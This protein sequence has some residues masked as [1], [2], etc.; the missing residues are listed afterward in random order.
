M[1][2]SRLF[3]WG[4]SSSV[5]TGVVLCSSAPSVNLSVC[6]I[7]LQ[8]C[9]QLSTWEVDRLMSSPD[10]EA[11]KKTLEVNMIE[12]SYDWRS[13]TC[14]NSIGKWVTKI[15]D[16]LVKWTKMPVAHPASCES[17]GQILEHQSHT[18][19]SPWGSPSSV[20]KQ[21]EQT[22]KRGGN[23]RAQSARNSQI[24]E[25][26]ADLR[27]HGNQSLPGVKVPFIYFLLKSLR[28][29]GENRGTSVVK[30]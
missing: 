29:K 4:T 28:G 21:M 18:E 9:L 26:G 5:P 19:G 10:A 7:L 6:H 25:K 13:V 15:W 11:E 27:F 14:Q 23:E 20:G 1:Q 30:N 2:Y 17:K 24:G 16:S 12:N 8:K 3:P 22:D